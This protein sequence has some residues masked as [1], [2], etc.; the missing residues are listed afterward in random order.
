MRE[1]MQLF[2]LR[3]N[4]HLLIITFFYLYTGFYGTTGQ[5]NDTT[6]YRH[7]LLNDSV[8]FGTPVT[9]QFDLNCVN[10]T[11]NSI[12]AGAATQIQN[13]INSAIQSTYTKNE[14]DNALALKANTSAIT[15]PD[16][17]SWSSGTNS[18][19]Y[20][21]TGNVGLIVRAGTNNSAMQILGTD[22]TGVIGKAFF[23]IKVQ[24]QVIFI[25][26][27]I[28]LVLIIMQDFLEVQDNTMTQ[29]N[30]DTSY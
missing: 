28:V 18:Y 17:A 4:L 20:L 2:H 13:Q 29:Q 24:M 16:I 30:I 15:T 26:Q 8:N 25:F 9:C 3:L 22:N 23:F 21:D 27:I 10:L 11:A 14:I 12:Y 6:K 7:K 5:E 19:R 1:H